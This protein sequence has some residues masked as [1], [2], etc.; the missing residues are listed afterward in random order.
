MTKQ[1][2]KTRASIGPDRVMRLTSTDWNS[3]TLMALHLKLREWDQQHED[4]GYAILW[5]LKFQVDKSAEKN[6][7][8]NYVFY[9]SSNTRKKKERIKEGSTYLKRPE[10]PSFCP[11]KLHS[12]NEYPLLR[13]RNFWVYQHEELKHCSIWWPLHHMAV[14]EKKI[15]IPQ[16]RTKLNIANQQA[17]W[18]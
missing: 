17:A 9:N 11:L 7:T 16:P 14:I 13:C 1:R 6:P 18:I 5:S 3:S 10:L 8:H 4:Q 2:L 15:I 12:A